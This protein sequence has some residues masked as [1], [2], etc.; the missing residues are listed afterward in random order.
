MKP[1]A[2]VLVVLALLEA[3]LA[4]LWWVLLDG[5]RT[6]S[7]RASGR[8]AESAAVVSTTL[9]ALMGGLAALALVIWVVLRRRGR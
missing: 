3:G 5:L 4:V 2:R 7:L 9:G 8:V 6:G 1:S